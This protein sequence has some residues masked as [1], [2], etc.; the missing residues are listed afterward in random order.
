MRSGD[1]LAFVEP[2]V[3]LAVFGVAIA[4]VITAFVYEGSGVAPPDFVLGDHRHLGQLRTA[5]GALPRLALIAIE[6]QM[7]SGET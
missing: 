1:R 7:E 2:L 4:G 5:A 6:M 3:R